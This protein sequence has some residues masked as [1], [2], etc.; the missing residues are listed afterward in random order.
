MRLLSDQPIESAAED[1][2]GLAPFV[3]SLRRAL[4]SSETPFVYG[5]LGE[6]GSGRTSALR[7]LETRLRQEREAATSALVP[8]WLNAR[9]YENEVNQIYPLLY[10]L[11][12][13]YQSDRRITALAGARGFGGMFARV[14]ATTALAGSDAA[15]RGATRNLAGEALPLKDL[16]EQLEAVRQQPENLEGLL[17]GW[18]DTVA[19][20]RTGFEALL[21]TFAS[22]LARADPRLKVEEV[23]FAILIDDLDRCAPEHTRALLDNLRQFLAVRRAGFV[24][25]INAPALAQ[26]LSRRYGGGPDAAR[27]YLESALTNSVHLPEPAAEQVLRFARQHLERGLEAGDADA[28]PALKAMLERGVDEG[29]RALEEGGVGNPR[30]LKRVLNR[31]VTFID[32]HAANLEQFSLANIARLLA[33]AETEPDLFQAFTANAERVSADL[34]NLGGPEFSLPAFETAHN[35]ILRASHARLV[36]RRKLFQFEVNADK[37]GLQQQVNEV[38]ALVRW[39]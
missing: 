3:E 14:A 10:A 7:L 25:A 39:S 1:S 20:L 33:I 28:E 2:L 23:R 38:D 16:R 22:D 32:Q 24:L 4:E 8:V 9:Q 31:Y 27:L 15:L 18:A 5:L 6:W 11:R 30:Q 29:A 26:A 35:V 37:P 34:V 21:G 17:R 13:A 12:Q 36:A 19:Q